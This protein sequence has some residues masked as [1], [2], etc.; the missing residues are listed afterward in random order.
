MFKKR[1]LDFH[2]CIFFI[3]L[4]LL[5]ML[6]SLR[7]DWLEKAAALFH[8]HYAPALLF[9]VALMFLLAMLL[10]FAVFITGIRKR[11]TR[12]N[13]ELAILRRQVEKQEETS[14]E[15]D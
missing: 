3:V 10:Y 2:Y 4:S 5:L 8:V 12:L 14:H 7:V 1:K 6:V 11:V 9:A 15:A 13:Q